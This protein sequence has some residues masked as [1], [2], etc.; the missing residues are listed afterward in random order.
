MGTYWQADQTCSFQ[1]GRPVSLLPDSACS[2]GVPCLCQ[3]VGGQGWCVPTAL[4]AES[5]GPRPMFSALSAPPGKNSLGIHMTAFRSASSCSPALWK[6]LF[7]H[8]VLS[9][10]T[11]SCHGLERRMQRELSTLVS[12]TINVRVRPPM[13]PSRSAG[14]SGSTELP[15]P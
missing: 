1:T 8:V 14:I 7:G 15:G 3:A 11:G 4:G 6:V 10:G 13:R 9:G 12:P 2:R 5:Q